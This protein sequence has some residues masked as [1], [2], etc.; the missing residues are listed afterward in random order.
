MKADLERLIDQMISSGILFEEALREFEKQFI[1]R[2]LDRHQH[3]LSKA[4]VE[5]GIHRNTLS[6]RIAQYEKVD[7]PPV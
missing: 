4:A 1:L 2:V 6:R 5:L 7:R 3:N